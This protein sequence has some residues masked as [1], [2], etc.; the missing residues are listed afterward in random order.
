MLKILKLGFSSTWAENFQTSQL[1]LEKA[2]EPE[3]KLPTLGRS[4]RKQRNSRKTSI[5]ASLNMLSLWLCF[6]CS[7]IKSYLT[8]CDPM[9]WSSPGFSVLRY[10][11]ELARFHVYWVDNAIQPSHALL[12]ASPPALNL[13]QHHGLFHWVSSPHQVAKFLELQRQSFQWILRID[14]L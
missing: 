11:P 4:W 9:D 10:L 1:G 13:S 7:V 6:Y 2:E 14:F 8:L 3:I 12:P 5:S